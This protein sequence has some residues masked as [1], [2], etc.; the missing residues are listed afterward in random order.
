MNYTQN[1]YILLKLFLLGRVIQI[2]YLNILSVIH[3]IVESS[4]W[5]IQ[6]GKQDLKE[7]ESLNSILC[8]FSCFFSHFLSDLWGFFKI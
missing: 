8:P 2:L 7:A 4:L 5:W 3:Y 6:S 1:L